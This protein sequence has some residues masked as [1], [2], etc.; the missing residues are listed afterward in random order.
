MNTH[1]EELRQAEIELVSRYDREMEKLKIDITEKHGD[2]MFLV[3]SEFEA[4]QE[5]YFRERL[6]YLQEEHD[7]ELE[8]LRQE[9]EL[10]LLKTRHELEA[11]RDDD[12][13]RIRKLQD[14]IYSREEKILE[15]RQ[16]F[17]KEKIVIEKE[18]ETRVDKKHKSTPSEVLVAELRREV[19]EQRT[20]FEQLLIERNGDFEEKYQELRAYYE[21]ETLNKAMDYAKK[22]EEWKIQADTR[23]LIFLSVFQVFLP[24]CLSSLSASSFLRPVLRVLV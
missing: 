7:T 17:E 20:Y 13:Q 16:N 23:Y 9:Y 19:A 11:M 15:M 1:H 8:Q 14:E 5:N 22:E 24:V 2:D 6:R 10:L 3:M 4:E 21:A 12:F 18:T